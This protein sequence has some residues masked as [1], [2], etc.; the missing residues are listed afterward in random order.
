MNLSAFLASLA[1]AILAQLTSVGAAFAAGL[2]TIAIGFLSHERDIG[3]KVM[4]K[5]HTTL[6]A[7]QAAGKSNIDAIE[8]AATAAY[9]EFC[10]DEVNEFKD[11]A[12]AIITLLVSS[13]KSAAG[14]VKTAAGA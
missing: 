14:I 4:D 11:E 10:H 12:N 8:E 6:I 3:N 5:F 9:N 2:G 13:A 1:A 7:A